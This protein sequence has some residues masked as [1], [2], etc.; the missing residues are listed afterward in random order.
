MALCSSQGVRAPWGFL[1]IPYSARL[2]ALGGENVS[3][4]DGEISM[5]LNNPALLSE[6]TDKNIQLSYAFLGRGLNA[7][8][9]MYAHN[10]RSKQYGDSI[11]PNY[12]AV[13][14]CFLDYGKFD[15]ADEY[16]QKYGTFTAKDF[17]L[18]IIYARQLG[19]MFSIGVAL[20]PIYSVYEAYT[21]FALGADVGAHFQT[22][23]KSFQMGLSL[24][25]IGWQLKSFYQENGD[26]R[27]E[28]LPLNLTLGLNYK[29]THAPIR[30][31]LTF[32]HLQQWDLGYNAMG[33][34]SRIVTYKY[35]NSLKKEGSLTNWE[36][37]QKNGAVLWT[38]MLFRH[39]IFAIDIVPKSE[40]FFLTLSYNHRRHQ[41]LTTGSDLS[42]AG[43]GL[44][45]GVKIKQFKLSLA[46]SQMTKGNMTFQ[47]SLSTNINEFLR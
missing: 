31:C 33:D 32:H 42:L 25:N 9:A 44:G 14:L 16:G 12:F 8:N 21:S 22:T 3:V 11:K 37:E 40:R 17:A 45:A 6:Q 24:K 5:A 47:V 29:L 19:R 35:K 46:L 7:G 20:K 1:S 43:F 10:F 30:F 2:N 13:S 41:E 4:R 39:V 15:Y 36:N 34:A 26:Q 18:N 38:D 23:D 28:N 27:R